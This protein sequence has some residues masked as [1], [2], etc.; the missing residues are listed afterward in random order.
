MS[1]LWRLN[2]LL[3]VKVTAVADSIHIHVRRI[4]LR[5]IACL[6]SHLQQSH[7]FFFPDDKAHFEMAHNGPIFITEVEKMIIVKPCPGSKLFTA[8]LMRI[9]LFF[10]FVLLSDCLAPGYQQNQ[11]TN[12]ELSIPPIAISNRTVRYKHVQAL[13]IKTKS[14]YADTLDDFVQRL[15]CYATFINTGALNNI[16]QVRPFDPINLISVKGLRPRISLEGDFITV[17][18]GQ[19]IVA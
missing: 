12:T 10:C 1:F 4:R 19:I 6:F 3:Q 16:I 17:V 15:L 2:A 9:F 13:M 14:K 11:R 5:F 18:S 8:Q 7:F